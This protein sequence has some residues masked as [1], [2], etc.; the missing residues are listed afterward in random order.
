[1]DRTL[2]WV[3]SGHCYRPSTGGVTARRE[4]R[5]AR[6]TDGGSYVEL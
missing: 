5:Q 1:M 6:R 4:G 2:T 3:R